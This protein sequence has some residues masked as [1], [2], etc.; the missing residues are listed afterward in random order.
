MLGNGELSGSK[1]VRWH[2]GRP[3]R[4]ASGGYVYHMLNCADTRPPIF[5]GPE[6]FAAFERVLEEAVE[7]FR[8]R[9]LSYAA[10]SG[11]FDAKGN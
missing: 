2:L 11:R 4:P 3:H 6:D 7:R 8:M 1:P 9:L 10:S 5:E